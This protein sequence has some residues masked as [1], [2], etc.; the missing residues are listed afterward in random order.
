MKQTLGI[1]GKGTRE[2]ALGSLCV[3]RNV[4]MLPFGCRYRLMDFTLSNMTNH[5]ITSIA[6]YPGRKIRSTMDHLGNGQPWDLN[7]RFQGI[8]LFPPVLGEERSLKFGE[9]GEYYSTVNF[10]QQAKEEYVYFARPHFLTKTDLDE[11]FNF[12]IE[13]K[14]DVTLLYSEVEDPEGRYLNTD[15]VHLKE[16]GSLLNLGWNLGTEPSFKMYLGRFFIRKDLFVELLK[17]ALEK[18][19]AT[20]VEEIFNNHKGDLRI[21]GFCHKGLVENIRDVASYYRANLSLLEDESYNAHFLEGGKVYTKTKDEPPTIYRPGARTKNALIANGCIIK[22]EV[23]RSLLFRGVEVEQEALV[24]NS[25][26]MQGSKIG[27]GAVVIHAIIDKGVV[28]HEG[29]TIVGS[30]DA[31]YVVPK[32][33]E[34]KGEER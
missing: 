7:R 18:G 10:F 19:N 8:F 33:M 24:R 15:K 21:N 1:I 32:G 13:S 6:I 17:D 3:S 29:V 31:P 27:K 2:S 22:G 5:G 30:A 20:T 11:A 16:D 25:I 14:G 4:E 9:V 34:I 26:V 28:I 23:E 12:F